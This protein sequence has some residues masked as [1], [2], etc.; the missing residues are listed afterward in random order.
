MHAPSQQLRQAAQ[1]SDEEVIRAVQSL[2]VADALADA[3][4]AEQREDPSSDPA[5]TS[6]AA[7]EH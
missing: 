3:L 6:A 5:R 2:F 4:D 7:N 1:R